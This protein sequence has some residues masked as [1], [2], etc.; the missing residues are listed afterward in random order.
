VQGS[1]LPPTAQAIISSPKVIASSAPS[2]STP[3]SSP[4]ASIFSVCAA[5]WFLFA[6]RLPS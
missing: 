5:A 3:A 6:V 1:P 2:S 4:A